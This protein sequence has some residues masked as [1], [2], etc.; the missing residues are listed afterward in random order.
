MIF[1]IVA[2]AKCVSYNA[3]SDKAEHI[4]WDDL[5]RAWAWTAMLAINKEYGDP[6]RTFNFYTANLL[7]K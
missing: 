3:T 6:N 7:K 2:K 5:A 4:V 1:L